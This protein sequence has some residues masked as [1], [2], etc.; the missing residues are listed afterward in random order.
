LGSS[1]GLG[2]QEKVDRFSDGSVEYRIDQRRPFFPHIQQSGG[3]DDVSD[4]TVPDGVESGTVQESFT[5]RI[6][7]EAQV[8]VGN[9]PAGESPGFPRNIFDILVE[10]LEH[11]ILI[12]LKY[13]DKQR[14][15]VFSGGLS[16][17][18]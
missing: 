4:G 7:G 9:G 3:N 2:I 6:D 14:I 18:R 15:V 11:Q 16:M 10:I 8:S 12:T 17:R 13:P 1:P 5:L